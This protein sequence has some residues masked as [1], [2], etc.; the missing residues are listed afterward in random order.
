LEL[1]KRKD[2]IIKNADKNLGVTVMDRSFYFE[3]ALSQRHLG[4]CSTYKQILNFPDS[5]L[6]IESLAKILVKYNQFESTNGNISVFSNDLLMNLVDSDKVMPCHMYFIPKI[7]KTPIALRPICSS[8]NSSTYN[9][10]K[11]LDIILQPIMKNIKSFI[12]NS[13]E[14]VC[15]LETSVFPADCQLLEADV[16]NLYPSI[17]I[18]DGLGSLRLALTQHNWNGAEIGFVIDLARWVLTNNYIQ[19]GDRYFLQLVGTAMGTPFAVTFACIHL[20]IIE[21]ESFEIIK[22]H[23]FD[24]PLLYYRFIDDIIA[25]FPTAEDGK[26]FMTVFNTRRS[27]IHCPKYVLSTNA[28]TFLDITI[29]KGKRFKNNGLLD[30]KLHQKPINK[31]LFLPPSSYHP[32]HCMNGWI[33]GYIK[34]IRLNCS[35]DIDY[36]HF[37]SKFFTHLRERGHTL[38]IIEQFQIVYN[39]AKLLLEAHNS[40]YRKIFANPNITASPITVVLQHNPRTV[41]LKNDIR[42]ILKP[43]LFTKIDGD[44]K[45]I[46]GERLS[47]RCAWTNGTSLL[48]LI[49]RSKL[50]PD[51]IPIAYKFEKILDVRPSDL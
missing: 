8:I 48:R 14:L 10:S 49:T 20:A 45:L 15:K 26:A 40:N 17:K 30:V 39:R 12:C 50:K 2:I 43:S 34:R 23:G 4:N 13:S 24:G 27:G 42:R 6:L 7:H 5:K 36:L 1:Y 29:F 25:V 16:E 51:D 32:K 37:K 31:F 3:E 18:E 44:C 19:F 11:Y 47:P 22:K 21:A 38:S 28:A 46:F 33:S 35:E 9:A 41:I